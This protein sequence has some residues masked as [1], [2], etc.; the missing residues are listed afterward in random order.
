MSIYDREL[1]FQKLNENRRQ[2][3]LSAMQNFANFMQQ[4]QQIKNQKVLQD[5]QANYYGAQTGNLTTKQLA[6]QN[7][8]NGVGLSGGMM[9]GYKDPLTGATY[10]T[11]QAIDYEREKSDRQS[12]NIL[13]RGQQLKISGQQ[14]QSSSE[15]PMP[16]DT[17]G[18]AQFAENSYKSSD[19][20]KSLLF[21]D[22]TTNSFRQD[23]VNK[24]FFKKYTKD[25]EV[26]NL[27]RW[28]YDTLSARGLIASGTTMK[29][30]EWDRLDETY[31]IDL[32]S[33]PESA[34]ASLDENR[35]YMAGYL[36]K[37][38][39]NAYKDFGSSG[40]SSVQYEYKTVNGKKYR[41][42]K[43]G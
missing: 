42:K 6:Y 17:A 20:V 23:L 10:K 14:L 30:I 16:A 35:E 31:G 37:L 8:M 22:G 38:R 27:R 26:Q 41:R 11:Q 9:T 32:F 28:V 40:G 3:M 19:K 24:A 43:N 18:R 12:E 21:P 2:G 5:A 33:A 25:P 39:P 1:E 29:D 4:Q 15:Q 13:K 36:K 7:M 34:M